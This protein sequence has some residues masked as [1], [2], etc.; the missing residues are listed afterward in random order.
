MYYMPPTHLAKYTDGLAFKPG[1]ASIR[2][3]RRLQSTRSND[4]FRSFRPIN[5]RRHLVPVKMKY[6]K[7]TFIIL[8]IA[9]CFG[10]IPL[11]FFMNVHY[12]GLGQTLQT[13]FVALVLGGF[14]VLLSRLFGNRRP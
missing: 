9:I 7:L 1:H 5:Q 2:P 13:G 4:T 14:S 8:A 10:S 11:A 3:P 6:L 12:F